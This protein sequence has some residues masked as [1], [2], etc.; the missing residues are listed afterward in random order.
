[1]AGGEVFQKEKGGEMG[2]EV[3]FEGQVEGGD[4]RLAEVKYRWAPEVN[5]NEAVFVGAVTER[6]GELGDL[7]DCMMDPVGEGESIVGDSQLVVSDSTGELRGELREVG[8]HIMRKLVI[9]RGSS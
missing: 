6:A 2:V 8:D 5:V 4:K 3:E 7:W 9:E 1:M